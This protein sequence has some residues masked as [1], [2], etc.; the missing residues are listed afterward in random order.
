MVLQVRWGS[1]VTLWSQVLIGTA[2]SVV[3]ASGLSTGSSVRV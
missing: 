3:D 2:S 1:S